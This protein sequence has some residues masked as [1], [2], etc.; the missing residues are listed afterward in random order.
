MSVNQYVDIYSGSEV[1]IFRIKE[2]LE[3]ENIPTII[4]ND[5][6]SGNIAGFMGGTPSTIRLKV[7]EMD[8]EKAKGLIEKDLKV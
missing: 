5:H 6:S 3:Q 8:F 1:E 2:L 7:R 4:Q